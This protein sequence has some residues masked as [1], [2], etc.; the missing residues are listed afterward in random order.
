MCSQFNFPPSKVSTGLTL[1]GE[2]GTTVNTSCANGYAIGGGTSV[3]GS[4]VSY[5]SFSFHHICF[6]ETQSCFQVYTCTG[7]GVGTSAWLPSPSSSATSCQEA[8]CPTYTFTTGV[9]SGR[10]LIGNMTNTVTTTCENGYS[11]G[12]GLNTVVTQVRDHIAFDHCHLHILCMRVLLYFCVIDM[13]D[14]DLH[15]HWCWPRP[16]FMVTVA[17]SR[18]LNMPTNGMS[19]SFIVRCDYIY[20]QCA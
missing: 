6:S 17:F 14:L 8:V 16:E 10:V 15:M 9:S 4:Q 13:R 12:G 20:W 5:I 11:I 3:Q 7:T 18:R 2:T 1:I 19:F